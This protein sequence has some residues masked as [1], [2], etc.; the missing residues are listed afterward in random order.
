MVKPHYL[1]DIHRNLKAIENVEG[2][3]N[4]LS[5]GYSIV[6]NE[7]LS[8]RTSMYSRRLIDA[9]QDINKAL[10]KIVADVVCDN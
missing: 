1:E 9:I 8:T 4:I 3:L 2:E 5:K 6:G 10:N 7:V